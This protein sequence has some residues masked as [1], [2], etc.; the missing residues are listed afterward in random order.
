MTDTGR[1][2]PAYIRR[3][4]PSAPPPLKTIR[5][6]CLDCC[7]GSAHEVRECASTNCPLWPFRMGRNPYLEL[8]DEERERRRQIGRAHAANILRPSG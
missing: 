7:A 5:A 1:A 2:D 4:C 6:K 3:I 8:S